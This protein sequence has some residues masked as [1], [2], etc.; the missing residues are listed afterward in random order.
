VAA[1]HM[2]G[3]VFIKGKGTIVRGSMLGGS[4]VLMFILLFLF[5][6][7]HESDVLARERALHAEGKLED[8]VDSLVRMLE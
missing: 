3:I 5:C 7:H 1:M 2:H 8:C 6:F 4:F